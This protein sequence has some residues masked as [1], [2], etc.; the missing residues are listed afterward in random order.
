MPARLTA[1][2][3]SLSQNLLPR[4]PIRRQQELMT[5]AQVEALFGNL[6]LVHIDPRR[7]GR[8]L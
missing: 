8:Q 3:R 6:I 7:D 1:R 4:D 2:H 5:A